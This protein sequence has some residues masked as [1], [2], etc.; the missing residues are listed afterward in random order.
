MTSSLLW[1]LKILSDDQTLRSYL[2]GT[3]HIGTEKA[4][5]IAE[6][7]CI[8][9]ISSG[10]LYNETDLKELIITPPAMLPEGL[11]LPDLIPAKNFIRCT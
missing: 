8:Y 11:G 10:K 4:L 5:A 7:S 3:M 9:L 2:F 1:E 6:A